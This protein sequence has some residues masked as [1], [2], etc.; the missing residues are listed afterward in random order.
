MN[1]DHHWT[2]I[3]SKVHRTLTVGFSCSCHGINLVFL[4]FCHS[5]HVQF[6]LSQSPHFI[7]K[8]CM[9]SRTSWSGPCPRQP[10]E[11]VWTAWGIWGLTQF[12]PWGLL[13]VPTGIS[14]LSLLNPSL[15]VF[16]EIFQLWSSLC[17]CCHINKG[18]TRFLLL[19]LCTSSCAE[20]PVWCY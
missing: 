4:S 17:L 19:R 13:W 14:W 12:C 10:V 15:E 7:N 8:V 18:D 3:E 11:H 9:Q 16:L 20:I 6:L 2:G 1:K 5:K